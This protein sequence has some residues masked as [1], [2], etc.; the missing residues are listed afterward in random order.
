MAK[1][2]ESAGEIIP[3]FAVSTCRLAALTKRSQIDFEIE[4]FERILSRDSNYVEVLSNLG[5]LFSRKGW[6]RRALQVDQRLAQMRPHDP[7]VAYNLA[8]S[9]AILQHAVEAVDALRRAIEHGYADFDHMF[10]DPDLA[11]LRGHPDYVRLL[12]T[13]SAAASQTRVV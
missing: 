6:H 7:I 2:K 8:C 3:N 13:L 4:F 10:Q 12:K 5:E 1:D 11:S 9:Y